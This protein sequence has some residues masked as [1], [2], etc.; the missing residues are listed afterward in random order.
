LSAALHVPTTVA[1][2]APG[3]HHA[4]RVLLGQLHQ[5]LHNK[6]ESESL[7]TLTVQRLQRLTLNGVTGQG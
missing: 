6:L 5:E 2:A 1:F 7:T 3:I 4:A